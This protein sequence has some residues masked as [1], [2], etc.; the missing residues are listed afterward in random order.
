MK[1]NAFP[2]RLRARLQ[3]VNRNSLSPTEL[4]EHGDVFLHAIL[5]GCAFRR[6]E[7]DFYCSILT[8]NGL[9]RFM[10][11]YKLFCADVRAEFTKY[12]QKQDGQIT[13]NVTLRRVLETTA[14]VEKQRVLYILS[15]CL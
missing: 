6:M 11:L 3:V 9:S 10:V 2:R 12:V 4:R 15:V 8:K 1:S 5:Q 7:S 13:Y 14:A